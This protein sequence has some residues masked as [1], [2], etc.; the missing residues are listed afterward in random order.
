ML[1]MYFVDCNIHL[2]YSIKL[3]FI[4]GIYCLSIITN[5]EIYKLDSLY[6]DECIAVFLYKN[7]VIL[8]CKKLRDY[9]I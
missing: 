9:F 1:L 7:I 6:I 8:C 4:T 2:L 3:K 5:I